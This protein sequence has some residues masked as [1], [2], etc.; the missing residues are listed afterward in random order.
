MQGEYL[1]FWRDIDLGN[2]VDTS[3]DSCDELANGK[4]IPGRSLR[5]TFE[6]YN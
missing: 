4:L 1:P 5:C 3:A 6:L 2:E